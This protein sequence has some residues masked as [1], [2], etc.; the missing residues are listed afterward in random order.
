VDAT[1]YV[2]FFSYAAVLG[3]PA[4]LLALYLMHARIPRPDPAPAPGR[5]APEAGEVR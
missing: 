2:F 5:D 3:L 1:S 4:I